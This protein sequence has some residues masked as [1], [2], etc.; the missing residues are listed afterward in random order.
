MSSPTIDLPCAPL[1]R[2]WTELGLLDPTPPAQDL[3]ARLGAWLDVRQAIRLHQ[4][5]GTGVDAPGR[6]HQGSTALSQQVIDSLAQLK[7]AIAHDRF[8]P[9]LWRNPMPS[10]VSWPA[11]TWSEFWEP[12]RRYWVDHQ[13]QMTLVLARLRRQLRTAL[14][15]AGGQAQAL[16]Q[17]D[18]ICD[19]TL[20]PRETRL[21]A[22]MPYKYEQRLSRLLQGGSWHAEGVPAFAPDIRRCLLAELDLRSQPVC[23]L[24]EA[25]QSHCT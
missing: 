14:S 2:F 22:S 16:A 11:A 13:K 19:Q 6:V 18:A 4:L 17:L 1:A 21:L 24:L 23:G 10:D 25:F 7:E 3:G 5:L 20:T 9:G 8:A 12:H 15:D